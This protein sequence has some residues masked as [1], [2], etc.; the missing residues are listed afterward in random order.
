MVF[1]AQ[2]DLHLVFIVCDILLSLGTLLA[3]GTL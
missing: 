2:V 1:Q 3:G